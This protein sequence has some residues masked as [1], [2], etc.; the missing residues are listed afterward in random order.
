MKADTKAAP[1]AKAETAKAEPAAKAAA[2]APAKTEAA[3]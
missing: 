2:A 3:P 1:A